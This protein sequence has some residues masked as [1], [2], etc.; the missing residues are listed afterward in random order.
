MRRRGLTV[1]VGGILVLACAVALSYAPVPYV[2]LEPGP[3]Y[4][5]LGV[6]EDNNQIIVID[7]TSTS[8]STGQLR[9]LTVGVVSQLSLFDAVVG[10]LRGDEAVVPRELVY[11]PD[12]STEEVDRHNAED[13]ANSLSSAEAAAL[14]RLGFPPVVGIKAVDPNSPNASV[15][16][17]GDIVTAVDGTP[18]P[19]PDALFGALKSKPAGSTLTFDLKRDG[20]ATTA[21]VSTVA[22]ADGTPEVEGITPEV[23][24]SAP[25]TISIPIEGIGGPSAGLMMALGITDKLDPADLTG[26]KIIAGTGTIDANG[27]VGPIGGVPQKLLGAKRAGATI[28]LTPKDNCAEAVR[29]AQPGLLLVQVDSLDTALTALQT[30]RDGGTPTLCPGAPRS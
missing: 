18:T 10:W 21:Q 9:F 2:A 25:F 5:T 15:L 13:F 30:L 20:A 12:E 29:N 19:T 14:T 3:T 28:F 24:S 4:N 8:D 6:D 22:G 23:R 7:G 1:L 26:G 17:A 27:A 16:K 11:P